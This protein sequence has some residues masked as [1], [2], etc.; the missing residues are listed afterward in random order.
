MP[1]IAYYLMQSKLQNNGSSPPLV[2]PRHRIGM[3]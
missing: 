2:S 3:R 1:K